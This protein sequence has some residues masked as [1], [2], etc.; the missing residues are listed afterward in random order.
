MT[1]D[2]QIRDEIIQYN[3]NREASKISS[4][5]SGKVNKYDYLTCD[6]I[7]PSNQK[8][9]REQ[10]KFYLL[11]SWQSFWESNKNN[12]RSEKKSIWCLRSN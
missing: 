6:E 11:S 3:I 1:I 5:S 9:I 2:D 10:A 7:L 4:L 12:W 8:Q